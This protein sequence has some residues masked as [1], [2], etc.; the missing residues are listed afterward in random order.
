MVPPPHPDGHVMDSLEREHRHRFA[1]PGD[2]SRLASHRSWGWLAVTMARSVLAVVLRSAVLLATALGAT[3]RASS[4][5]NQRSDDELLAWSRWNDGLEDFTEAYRG[6]DDC[7]AARV[8]ATFRS[9]PTRVSLSNRRIARIFWGDFADVVVVERVGSR[10]GVRDASSLVNDARR[11]NCA[12]PDSEFPSGRDGVPTVQGRVLARNVDVLFVWREDSGTW[13]ARSYLE[14]S[15]ILAAPTRGPARIGRCWRSDGSTWSLVDPCV[16]LLA[17]WAPADRRRVA[18]GVASRRGV[19]V[20]V[21]FLP[22]I[23]PLERAASLRARSGP[24]TAFARAA[25]CE[26]GRD[27]VT[28]P[29][30]HAREFFVDRHPVWAL[31][32]ADGRPIEAMIAASPCEPMTR[33]WSCADVLAVAVQARLDWCTTPDLHTG[34]ESPHTLD[35]PFGPLQAA[36]GFP[37]QALAWRC[38]S[39]PRAHAILSDLIRT[40]DFR[41]TPQLHWRERRVFVGLP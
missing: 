30:G 16:D 23:E 36:R 35:V 4:Q 14:S 26:R 39:P 38:E 7:R 31:A 12:L 27:D 8:S 22:E 28:T 6:I 33:E 13:V 19:G 11:S 29:S 9:T 21:P 2:S 37:A 32:S 10:F 18:R 34:L 5:S 24:C 20:R 15:A 41:V 40:T 3:P 25:T 17:T 1:R